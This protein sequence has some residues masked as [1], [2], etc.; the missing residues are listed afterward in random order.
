MLSL[1]SPSGHAKYECPIKRPFRKGSGQYDL[2]SLIFSSTSTKSPRLLSWPSA[3]VSN[4]TP[5]SLID[6][7][8]RDSTRWSSMTRRCCHHLAA[9]HLHHLHTTLYPESTIQFKS[10]FLGLTIPN[11]LF[12]STLGLNLCRYFSGPSKQSTPSNSKC[13]QGQ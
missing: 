12:T 1:I 11:C 9:N 8:D 10:H 7:R 6:L 5:V 13:R 4:D 2:D 3:S